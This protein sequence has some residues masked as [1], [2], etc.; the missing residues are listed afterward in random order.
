M[1][2][3]MKK[4]ISLVLVLL[5]L[6][7]NSPISL[8]MGKDSFDEHTKESNSIVIKKAEEEKEVFSHGKGNSENKDNV[9]EE[10]N[11]EEETAEIEAL[12][13]DN[14]SSNTSE[15]LINSTSEDADSLFNQY[16]FENDE[17]WVL[18]EAD[19]GAFPDEVELNVK[20][21][22]PDESKESAE[23]FI[24]ALESTSNNL[25]EDQI[26]EDAKVYDIFFTDRNGNEVQPESKVKVN[27]QYKKTLTL[28]DAD[29]EG[30]NLELA[31][32]S[33]NNLVENKEV[34]IEKDLNGEILSLDFEA[35]S[36]SL[37]V[38]FS[39]SKT[40][41]FKPFEIG[42]GWVR[43]GGNVESVSSLPGRSSPQGW[44]KYL[45]INL[46]ELKEGINSSS[47]DVNDY[48]HKK[49]FS[50]LR[51]WDE[52]YKIEDYEFPTDVLWT[53]FKKAH[54]DLTTNY[55]GMEA[56]YE[57]TPTYDASAW[58]D[59][60]F[61]P[62]ENVLN[63]Y[64]DSS[65]S[66]EAPTPDEPTDNGTTY[67]VRYYHADGSYSQEDGVL[68]E[69]ENFTVSKDKKM[70]SD[71][72]YSGMTVTTGNKA[73]KNLN[74]SEGS[75]QID[76]DSTVNLVKINVYYKEY[77][78]KEQGGQV[79][80]RPRYDT[81]LDNGS[82]IY[83]TSRTGLHRDKRVAVN[84]DYAD[85]RTFDLTLETWNIDNNIANVGMV[86]DASG[87]MVWPS[88]QPEKIQKSLSEWRSLIGDNWYQPYRYLTQ[89][90]VDKILNREFTDNSKL[91]YNG[92]RYYIYDYNSSVLEYVPLG[93]S[94]GDVRNG[95]VYMNNN[96][97]A[98]QG[99]GGE[100]GWYYVN[101]GGYP[102]YATTHPYTA[103]QYIGLPRNRSKADIDTGHQMDS[104]GTDSPVKFYIDSNG[105]LKSF[106]FFG[107][108][109]TSYVYKKPIEA[110]TKSEV[111]QH[112]VGKFAAT[113]NVLS[114]ESQVSMT[115]FS[116]REF[117][118][119]QL[120][121][122]NWT[123]DTAKITAAM[124]QNYGNTETNGG[125]AFKYQ[126]GMNLYNYGITGATHTY[127]GIE[128]FIS[129]MTSN[130][131]ADGYKPKAINN[132]DS[133]YL[134]IFTD[135]K[136]NSGNEAESIRLANNLKNHGYTIMTV[137]MQSA[138]MT[139]GDV[140]HSENFLKGLASDNPSGGK[141][142]YSAKHNDIDTLVKA[143]E[144]MAKQ[145]A[146]PL[147]GYNIRDYIDPRFD[148]LD[149]NGNVLTKLNSDGKFSLDGIP[150]FLNDG[151][152]AILKYDFDKKMFYLEWENQDIPTNTTNVTGKDTVSIWT[153]TITVRAKEDF[154]GGNDILTNGNE[155]G[156][157][158]V[159]DPKAQG[160]P[161]TSKN[162]PHTTANPKILE[163][164]LANYEDTIFKGE[165]ISPKD[166][167]DKLEKESIKDSPEK[168]SS[169]YYFD[170]LKRIGNKLQND[171]NYYFDII[172]G[173]RQPIP[174][175]G[176]SLQEENL[177]IEVPYYYLDK[178][179]DLTS[180]AGGNLH[181]ADKVGKLTYSWV[182]EE[183]G[184]NTLTDSDFRKDFT[185]QTAKDV[186][187]SLEIKYEAYAPDL[188]VIE[189]D[190]L[191][192][193]GSKRTLELTGQTGADKLIR[194]PVGVVQ[195]S[196]GP[197][198]GVAV[199]HSVEGVIGIEKRVNKDE[200][201]SYLDDGESITFKFKVQRTYEGQTVDYA[202]PISITI[203]KSGLLSL[204][205]EADG[206]VVVGTEWITGLPIG[207]YEI[208]EILE[209]QAIALD[210]VNAIS[211]N[212]W[213]AGQAEVSSFDH[214]KTN[215]LKSY[216]SSKERVDFEAAN[217]IKTSTIS[218]HIG[219]Y[220]NDKPSKKKYPDSDFT[221]S[222]VEDEKKEVDPVSSTENGK[223][224]LAAQLGK[225]SFINK[226]NVGK[227][228]IEKID[229]FDLPVEGVEFTLKKTNDSWEP[230][231][232]K[233]TETTSLVEDKAIAIFSKLEPGKYLL[234]ETRLSN[235]FI[236]PDSKWQITV[237]DKGE[238][239]VDEI[240]VGETISEIIGE[241]KEITLKIKN[242]RKS[243]EL[244]K[245][246]G[247]GINFFRM[248]GFF[249]IITSFV[250]YIRK[251]QIKCER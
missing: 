107:D 233:R 86:F 140:T 219:Q 164:E 250:I 48:Y 6:L 206:N 118:L 37:Y 162:F 194:D 157:N 77:I 1:K 121:L 7:S 153:S 136:D 177:K 23:K 72:E 47:R 226:I 65:S 155:P 95:L 116:R 25:Q 167:F 239:S 13:E 207:D 15:E 79:D 242:T 29:I 144:D 26:I 181:Q 225:A 24:E 43:F 81:K 96:T 122:L 220:I 141:Y 138:G 244:P 18:V 196:E 36:F 63:I 199:I 28:K 31:H 50:Y 56:A 160:D 148:L 58:H 217:T 134:I 218:F 132:A 99:V 32:I 178:P 42:D 14:T 208:I 191:E 241:G 101:S 104:G 33:D 66:G 229:D 243:Y 10:E 125:S 245:T 109:N 53:S 91:N 90:Q 198:K 111:L 5:I 103:K 35:D 149:S 74:E 166:L 173:K 237:S 224:Y 41:T 158:K 165:N 170:Y 100:R 223:H 147:N 82:R 156:L 203:D 11:S 105:Y 184:S 119:S 92:Y 55:E 216:S 17:Y 2:I 240:T 84:E 83:D 200:L 3:K 195:D 128:A 189:G 180:Y 80:G 45:K 46:Y 130:N 174:G 40:S 51:T 88:D 171:E 120:A 236:A 185:S 248:T 215:E 139:S 150:V 231:G 22:I 115:R 249:I 62:D 232:E 168:E 213:D 19:S 192:D 113:L 20:E 54:E 21:I 182:I 135:G 146:K 183:D 38:I 133:K 9:L 59:H 202:D 210:S 212:E 186:K 4:I 108:V 172:S 131:S 209:D 70:N 193:N 187:Y 94:E 214:Q 71:E 112:S 235:E 161:S 251:R 12:N 190:A 73:V 75:A 61:D 247:S 126:D 60:G 176:V 114:P 68:S 228:I 57:A 222:V 93:Y 78:E 205:A 67:L 85:G 129:Q 154:L 175:D 197:H 69:G 246:G 143:F 123:N 159:Y 98:T 238:V 64:L 117:P 169:T 152:Q 234:S 16:V 204:V 44:K 145:I 8:A 163:F 227:L 230:T 188:E 211:P 76:Y 127:K 97:I 151:K 34:D 137:F 201:L 52:S 106:Y 30:N 124:N 110:E 27:F 102:E 39:T 89:D 221:L 179:G 49:S 142:F 87:S